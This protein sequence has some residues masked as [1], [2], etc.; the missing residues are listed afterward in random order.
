MQFFPGYPMEV[1]VGT[2][3]GADWW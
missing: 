2:W 3:C 1:R